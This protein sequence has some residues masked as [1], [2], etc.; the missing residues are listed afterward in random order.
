MRR[1]G[2]TARQWRKRVLLQDEADLLADGAVAGLGLVP[3]G[4]A[5]LAHDGVDVGNDALED[6]RRVGGRVLP[7]ELREGP[8]IRFA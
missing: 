7:E 5:D 2:R 6:H 1:T 8:D 4:E 3:P